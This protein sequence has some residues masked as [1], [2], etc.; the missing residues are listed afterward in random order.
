[1]HQ[2]HNPE[3]IFTREWELLG[4][5]PNAN[6]V[7]KTTPAGKRERLV[8]WARRYRE[9]GQVERFVPIVFI[10]IYAGQLVGPI[11]S[12]LGNIHSHVSW[13]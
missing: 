4:R 13:L 3:K 10:I 1:V 5:S 7:A 6:A 2:V 9:L 11:G 8:R 12:G